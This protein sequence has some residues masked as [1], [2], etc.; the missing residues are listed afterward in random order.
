MKYLL[1]FALALMLFST[2]TGQGM[3]FFHGKWEDAV[4]MA[5][6]QNKLIFVD[7]Y[8]TWC[9]PCKRM[10][11]QVFPQPEVGAFYNA[12]FI[13]VKMDMEKDE[14]RKFGRK[15]PVT[16]YPTFYW[17]DPDGNV[18][19]TTKGARNVEDFIALGEAAAKKF[20]GSAKYRT[21]YDQGDRD[22]EIVYH[23]IIT[24]NK[25]KKSSVKV[26][27]EY[28]KTQ[29]DLTT[30]ENL[31]MLIVATTR[32][33]SKIF[34]YLEQHKKALENQEGKDA[35]DETIRIAAYNTAVKAIEYESPGLIDEGI[36]A[37]K[38]HLPSEAGEYEV[39]SRMQYA[40]YMEDAETYASHAKIFIKKY[41]GDDEEEL[42]QV[43][44]DILEHFS[45]HETCNTIGQKAA[46]K[47]MQIQRNDRNMIVYATLV[48][49]GG[50]KQGAL[51]FLDD[52][53]ESIEVEGAS[54]KK[55][56]LVRKQLEAA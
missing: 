48:Y 10:S 56:S 39:S 17:I 2:S 16:A 52:A 54:T 30:E 32:V 35:V 12:N 15:Y 44:V 3:E 40:L 13:N 22:F 53:I 46:K 42:S 29:D 55:L 9:G 24:L 51:E 38:K 19:Y 4:K 26:A 27:N 33:D 18:V 8:T 41:A 28:F 47:A 50:D 37:M 11:A 45:D 1:T 5:Q 21:L 31:K 20:D 43:A 36:A 14:G 23:Y 34:G 49:L 6:E 25:S 7:S